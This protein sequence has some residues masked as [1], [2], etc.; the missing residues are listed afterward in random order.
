METLTREQHDNEEKQSWWCWQRKTAV[1]MF[2]G[3]VL[4]VLVIYLLE[5]YL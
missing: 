3:A 5:R 1:P 2:V 4:L